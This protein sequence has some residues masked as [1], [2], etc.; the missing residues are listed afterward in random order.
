MNCP[1]CGAECAV[2]ARFCWSCG[3][4]LRAPT[5]ERRVV[6]VLFAD[7]VG[8]TALS[9][10]RDPEEVKRLVED[11]FEHL[12]R[13]VTAFGGRVDKILGDAIVALF[14]A[15]VAH[16]DDAERAVRASLRMQ[17]SLA[18]YSEASDAGIRMRIGVN[19]GE[20]L[21]GA[22]SAGGDYTAMGDVVNTASRLQTLAGP[23]EVLVGES[24]YLATS[25]VIDYESRGALVAR[26]RERPVN[27]W[28][29][30]A[31]ILPPG[32]RPRRLVTPLIGRDAEM[33]VLT[34]AVHLSITSRRGLHVVLVGEA[35]VGKT[36]LANELAA[37][38]EATDGVIEV[39]GR[40]VP[41]GEANPWWP[42]AEALRAGCVIGRDDPIDSARAQTGR[43]VEKFCGDEASVADQVAIVDG[44]LHLMG[45]DTPLRRLDGTRARAEAS[46]ALLRFLEGVLRR[47][48]MMVRLADLHWADQ[49]VLE[50]LDDLSVQLARQPFV[51]VA[52]ARRS[53]QDRWTPKWGRYNAMVLNLT[54][55]N[56]DA[57]ATLLDAL[58]G[59]VLSPVDREALL[60]RS[61]GN[62]FYLEELVTL[63]GTAPRVDA[64]TA[65]EPA[66]AITESLPDTLRGL[67]AA[68]VDG[69]TAEEQ[70]VLE[71]A[72]VWGASGPVAVLFETA[73]ALRAQHDVSDVVQS[74]VDKD[75]LTLDGSDW[76]F[77]SDL[78]REV[79]YTRLTRRDRMTRHLGI[80]SYLDEHLDPDD[81]DDRDVET[82]AR[83]YIE[84]ARL[85]LSREGEVEPELLDRAVLWALIAGRR[86]EQAGAYPQSE[87]L[88]TQVLELVGEDAARQRFQAFI[89]RSRSR[90]EQWMT[91]GARED[92]SL[93]MAEA[94]RLE[95]PGAQAEAYLSLAAAAS[96]GGEVLLAEEE[97]DAALDLYDGRGDVRGRAEAFRQRGMARLLR[98]DQRG[99]EDPI[100]AALDAFRAIGDRRGEAWSLQNL[101]WIAL[102]DGR[103]D[104]AERTLASSREAFEEVG[105]AGG[106]A[107]ADGLLA[108]LSFLQGD[109]DRATVLADAVL[110]ASERR[111]DRYGEGMMHV[112]RAGIR[113]WRGQARA[114]SEEAALAVTALSAAGDPVGLEQ[115]LSVAGRAEVMAG[116][117][118]YG[119]ELLAEARTQSA[120]TSVGFA[121]SVTRSTEVQIGRPESAVA[122]LDAGV[123][124]PESPVPLDQESAILALA[125]TQMG[126][127][128]E[129]L[130]IVRSHADSWTDSAFAMSSMV[131]VLAAAGDVDGAIDAAVRFATLERATHLDQVTAD[132]ALALL[133][134]GESGDPV[135]DRA[136]SVADAT[137]DQVAHALCGLAAAVRLEA[138]GRDATDALDDSE[139]RL[140]VLGLTDT[141]W[142]E[143]YRTIGGF[144]AARQSAG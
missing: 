41:Y 112:V 66:P 59:S 24:T 125:L 96:R 120:V 50:L 67:V 87:R 35:G 69:L 2:G 40:C 19:T 86:A 108:Y 48:P 81:S 42:V 122:D 34:N 8:F 95:D 14:G 53:L 84:A 11:A 54:P 100:A 90:V 102:S 142:R 141:R 1:S 4:A 23:D 116:N 123:G 111:G 21:V 51:L 88:Y 62:P 110:R 20:V 55:L 99:A 129:A 94:E 73:A 45:Y 83:H 107:W 117:V 25:E 124:P 92:A 30:R 43:V 109:L 103:L 113:L 29:A 28:V 56:R 135:I 138:S 82:V 12:V 68:R 127:T 16:E 143:V 76:A 132:L 36:R 39:A 75:V 105:D 137:D 6:T 65:S 78:V 5:E 104:V 38:V 79:A 7:L 89:G 18:E 74:L 32:H 15:P 119:L 131:V 77:R 46:G 130:A 140:A 61:G 70:H 97:I 128:D 85:S 58:G 71:D 144:G 63:V 10:Q 47:Q 98:G 134:P 44:L 106:L 136:R 33:S 49:M 72:A 91:P 3:Q 118:E 26:G 60:D 57:S 52:T 37:V 17:E 31:A 93:A 121:R 27:V 13:D 101:A 9:E 114:S 64:D 139:R 126:R 80:A 115:A 133:D 22:L